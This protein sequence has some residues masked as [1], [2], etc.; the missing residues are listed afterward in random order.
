MVDQWAGSSDIFTDY[1]GTITEAS[2]I[3]GEY[4]TQMKLTFDEID[5][6]EDPVFEYY[7]IPDSYESNDGG[8]T[9]ER[10]DGK[11]KAMSK[12]CKWMRFV[13]AAGGL[14][15]VR[16]A[17]TVNAPLDARE[18]VGSRWRMEAEEGKPYNVTDKAT[19]EKKTGVSKDIN[20]PVA[21][22]GK[23]STVSTAS[24]ESAGS[25][26]NGKVD[27]LSVLN[28]LNNPELAMSIKNS[29]STLPYNEWFANSYAAIQTAQVDPKTIPD[30]LN[31]MAG[32]GLYEGL[33]GKG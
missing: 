22:L 26:G 23:D 16:E 31:A 25:N 13:R 2:F 10:V 18:W 11:D 4:G 20:F 15:G 14:K 27:Q 24:S 8:D 5:G 12:S 21:F 28:D 3:T 19:G 1:E 17:F 6:R 32:R 30:L 29:A 33:G 7:G 9:V